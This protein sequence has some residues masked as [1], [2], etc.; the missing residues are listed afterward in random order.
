MRMSWPLWYCI[1]VEAQAALMV[2]QYD[3]Y[4]VKLDLLFSESGAI[5]WQSRIER[6]PEIERLMKM[7]PTKSRGL[8]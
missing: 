7:P 1:T 2:Y 6:L 4:G 5:T 3:L 8:Y